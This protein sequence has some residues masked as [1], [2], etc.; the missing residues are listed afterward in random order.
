MIKMFFLTYGST[1]QLNMYREI[2]LTRPLKGEGKKWSL[3]TGGLLKK[4]QI[5]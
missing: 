2:S 5:T 1:S 4:V 3:N